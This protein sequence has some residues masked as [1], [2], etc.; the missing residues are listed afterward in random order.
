MDLSCFSQDRKLNAE[1]VKKE[2]SI[3]AEDF[4]IVNISRLE[5]I[6]GHTFLLN[7]FKILKEQQKDCFTD[8]RRR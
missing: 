5:P 8:Y 7:A 3:D 6:K 2:L 1:K 4:V